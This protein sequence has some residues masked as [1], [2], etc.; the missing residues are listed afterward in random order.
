M[1]RKPCP[2]N[3][4]LCT[5]KTDFEAIWQIVTSAFA[6]GKSPEDVRAALDYLDRAQ[7]RDPTIR[8]KEEERVARREDKLWEIIFLVIGILLGGGGVAAVQGV[9]NVAEA[10]SSTIESD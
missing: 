6:Q 10:A 8:L 9:A 5:P 3:D 4:R 2:P 7:Q 1:D